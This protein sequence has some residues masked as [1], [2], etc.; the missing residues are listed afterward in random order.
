MNDNNF[1]VRNSW[2]AL[3]ANA[4]LPPLFPSCRNCD[5]NFNIVNTWRAGWQQSPRPTLSIIIPNTRPPPPPLPAP[6]RKQRMGHFEPAA[7]RSWPVAL[8]YVLLGLCPP[9][10]CTCG[11]TAQ[12]AKHIFKECPTLNPPGNANPDLTNPDPTTVSLLQCLCETA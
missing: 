10:T 5:S 4:F 7:H 1:S 11:H 12:T 2:E 9:A 8:L 6:I 3:G